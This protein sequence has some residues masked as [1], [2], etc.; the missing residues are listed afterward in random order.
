[1]SIHK[2]ISLHPDVAGDLNEPLATE[3]SAAGLNVLSCDFRGHGRS[4]RVISAA[5][6]ARASAKPVPAQK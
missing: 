6:L 2:M 3:L 5:L 4:A 1:M